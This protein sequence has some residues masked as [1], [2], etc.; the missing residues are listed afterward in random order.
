MIAFDSTAIRLRSGYDVS[1]A[2]LLPFTRFDAS[3]KW[4]CQFFRRSR[5][6]VVSQSNRTQIVISTTS[7]VVEYVVVSSYCSRIV[8][9]SQLW[10]RLM[11]C[12]SWLDDDDTILAHSRYSDENC[13]SAL[14]RSLCHVSMHERNVSSISFRPHNILSNFHQ[15]C[16]KC[17]S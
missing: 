3:K 6:V 13:D 10:Y 5:V 16:S 12:S 4:T 9:E 1:R 7:V 15:N 8:I 2:R 11:R 17:C 14:N